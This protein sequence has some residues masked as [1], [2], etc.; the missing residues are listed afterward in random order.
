MGTKTTVNATI[1]A[2][3]R[4]NKTANL[5][6]EDGKSVKVTPR[7]PNNLDK[8]KVGDRL[9]ITYTESVAVKVERVEKV[10]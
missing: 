6:L 3:D 9:V 4:I 2:I 5:K 1:T 8:V 7:D 10:K